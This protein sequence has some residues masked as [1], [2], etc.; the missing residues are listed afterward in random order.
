M[1]GKLRPIRM[2]LIEFMVILIVFIV[3]IEVL[4]IDD[5]NREVQIVIE[6][7]QQ[8]REELRH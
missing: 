4:R 1:G 5:L 2:L 3:I 6:E 8:L 7:I